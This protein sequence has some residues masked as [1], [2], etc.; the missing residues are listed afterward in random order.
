MEIIGRMPIKGE[1]FTAKDIDGLG[2]L[3][4]K[5]HENIQ[6]LNLNELSG[7]EIIQNLKK[8]DQG[9]V[10][11]IRNWAEISGFDTNKIYNE[12]VQ[13]EWDAEYLDPNKYRIEIIDGK[14]VK[15]RG[16]RMNKRARK[17]ICWAYNREQEPHVYEGK[18]RI[19]DVLKRPILNAAVEKLKTQISTG[20]KVIGSKT[21]VEINVIEGNRYYNLKIQV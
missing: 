3:F 1:G 16:K 17:N 5:R 7:N 20:L 21:K 18:G 12:C 4:K 6:V 19:V 2:M 15:I 14:E 10:L 11:V 9:R 8:E 13:D